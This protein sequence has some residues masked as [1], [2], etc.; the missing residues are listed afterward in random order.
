MRELAR[1]KAQ[2]LLIGKAYALALEVVPKVHRAGG[3]A[4]HLCEVLFKAIRLAEGQ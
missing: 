1:P 2:D 3:D 4:R